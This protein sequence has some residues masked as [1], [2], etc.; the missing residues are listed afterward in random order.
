MDAP[1]IIG[2]K[3]APTD[4]LDIVKGLRMV[5]QAIEQGAPDHMALMQAIGTELLVLAL[6]YGPNVHE[7]PDAEFEGL[8]RREI[9]AIVL[10]VAAF[11]EGKMAE[12]DILT[13][14]LVRTYDPSLALTEAMTRAVERKKAA[15]EEVDSA[16]VHRT[17]EQEK[18]WREFQL[19]MLYRTLRDA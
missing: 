6:R 19:P 7:I 12:A 2:Q 13:E 15:K 11:H 8:I 4:K 10:N 18:M 17:P 14:R 16:L 1:I 5:A 9:V 3:L